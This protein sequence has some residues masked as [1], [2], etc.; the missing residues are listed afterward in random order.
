MHIN[1]HTRPHS[2]TLTQEQTHMRLCCFVY[3]LIDNN[4]CLIQKK[5]TI[6]I[7]TVAG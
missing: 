1:E 3:A 6:T 5:R 7:A 4:L 2:H